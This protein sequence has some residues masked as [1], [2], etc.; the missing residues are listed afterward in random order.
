MPA[1]RRGPARELTLHYRTTCATPLQRY[2]PA[3]LSVLCWSSAAQALQPHENGMLTLEG[4]WPSV[5]ARNC[6]SSMCCRQVVIADAL[7][8][9]MG[10]SM[11]HE[12]IG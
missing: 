6:M 5:L 1:A 7:G 2:V 8:L 4:I 12:D 3:T 11:P 10:L 9:G